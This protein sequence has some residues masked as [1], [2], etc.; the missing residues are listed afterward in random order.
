MYRRYWLGFLASVGGTQVFH[1]AQFWLVHHDL[2]GS[3]L[4]LGLV[5]LFNAIPAIA[6]NLVGGVFADKF[7]KRKLL[8]ATQTTQAILV[9]L[10]AT[11]T[12]LDLVRLW[13]I[14]AV[15]FLA[16]S[17]NA[18]DGPTRQA[19]YP[20]LIERK[21]LTSA[22][23]LNSSVWQGTRIV[24]PA[25]SGVV[26][27]V[28]GTA[29]A[30]FLAVL[31][32]VAMAVTMSRLKVPPIE[33]SVTKSVARDVIEGLKY[34][35][36]NSVFSFLMGMTFFNSF[37][38]MAYVAMMPVF[39][40]DILH[41]G[42]GAYGALLS[43]GGVGAFITTVYLGSRSASRQRGL[44][45]IG[46]ATLFGLAIATFALTSTYLRIFPLA[47]ALMFVMG[48]FNSSYMI[49]IQSSLQIMVPD[50]M[51]GRVMGFFGMTYSISPLGG[52]QAG[53]VASFMGVPF[54]I[55][56]GGLAV[57]AFALGPALVNR[58]VRDLGSLIQRLEGQA[59]SG[60]QHAP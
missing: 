13:H 48:V 49:S 18:F 9:L 32:Y 33:R 39:A 55:A 58:N 16:G 12:W 11:L 8:M 41:R 21:V 24:G 23:A 10:I 34:V 37:F 52:M 45:L 25:L 5:G 51:R 29:A 15:A 43:A 42:A 30:L 54:A 57:S 36:G 44:L 14:L 22:V 19:F 1:A 20:H 50:R 3:P 27:A 4:S 28:A 53:A 31:G 6:F 2:K 26:I 47:L 46:G 35:K 40:E 17:V 7:D 56:L 38:G 60:P 59:A